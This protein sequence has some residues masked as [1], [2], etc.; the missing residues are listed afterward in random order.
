MIEIAVA[1]SI[2]AS[3]FAIIDPIGNVPLFIAMTQNH[4]R[5]E[6][7]KV[8]NK[9]IIV[10][11]LT[12]VIFG[13]VG[14]YIFMLFNITI[15]AFQIAGGILIFKIGFDMLQGG[16]PS[17]K[18]T[19]DEKQEAIEKEIIGIVPL[20][21]PIFAGPGSI[22]AVMLYISQSQENFFNSIVQLVIVLSCVILT[23]GIS[24]VLLRNASKIFDRIGRLG[25]L[26][27][28]RIMGLIITAMAVQFL[29]NGIYAVLLN[30][31]LVT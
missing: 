9:V 19:E 1:L 30:W 8:I 25:T 3:I 4:S 20:G 2:F 14:Q 22:S 11:T 12:L 28:S 26:A 5:E 10:A 17:A 16:R 24:Y 23:M 29:L 13:L 21:I 15:P 18:R 31:N 6:K 27:I 7:I